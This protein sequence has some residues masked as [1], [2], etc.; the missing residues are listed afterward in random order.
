[1]QRLFPHFTAM[2]VV[3]M[4][5]VAAV[6]HAFLNQAVPPVGGTV[7]T[8]PKEVRLTFSE[9]IEPRFS[10]IEL[11]SVDGRAIATA[12]AI[13]DPKDEKQLVLAVPPLAPGRYKVSWH[14]VSVDTHRTE[15]A[16][17]FAVAP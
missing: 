8:S 3:G 15:G 7:P 13:R 14:V 2:V 6:A 16:Y 12:P 1:M 10:G 5:A 4:F 11:A 17:S 9:G